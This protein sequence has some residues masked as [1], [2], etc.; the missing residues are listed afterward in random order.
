MTV[1]SN[2]GQYTFI[3]T[4]G[5]W[6]PFDLFQLSALSAGDPG[7]PTRPWVILVHGFTADLNSMSTIAERLTLANYLCLGYQYPSYRNIALNGSRL[8]AL[9]LQQKWLFAKQLATPPFVIVAHSMGGLVSRAMLL[10]ANAIDVAHVKGL[11]RGIVSLGTPHDGTLTSAED[12]QRLMKAIRRYTESVLKMPTL[13]RGSNFS[14]ALEIAKEDKEKVIDKLNA[15]PS[16]PIASISGG[17]EYRYVA[18]GFLTVIGQ[19]FQNLW[20]RSR[21]ERPHDGLV[22]ERSSDITGV[23]RGRAEALKHWGK[24]GYATWEEINHSDLVIN[25]VVFGA[26]QEAIT[27]L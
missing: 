22:P 12:T 9:L 16:L 10:N 11:V 23:L 4:E 5:S 6:Q 1:P 20:I 14:A 24:S 26:L 19:A 15:A 27:S 18:G 25:Q 21:I 2:Q 3:W 7:F 8:R 17:W 13:H